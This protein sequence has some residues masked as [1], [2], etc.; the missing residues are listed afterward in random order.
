M[1]P[2]A[3]RFLGRDPIGYFDGPSHYSF[4]I[5]LVWLDPAGLYSIS[6]DPYVI[7]PD[8]TN[9]AGFALD[10]E[11]GSH[12]DPTSSLYNMAAA[13]GFECTQGIGAGECHEHCKDKGLDGCVQGYIYILDVNHNTHNDIKK[14][15]QALVDYYKSKDPRVKDLDSLILFHFVDVAKALGKIGYHYKKN[16]IIDFHFMKCIGNK[17][18][19]QPCKAKKGTG[20]LESNCRDRR[21]DPV[22]WLPTSE[23]PENIDTNRILSKFCCCKTGKPIE[24]EKPVTD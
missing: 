21:G 24:L 8:Y 6:D 18:E 11:D 9:C 19:Y 15:L 13:L 5:W 4:N 10:V 14:A 23:N 2:L 1:S 12:I 20:N 22:I 3:G 17:F 16:S 7:D